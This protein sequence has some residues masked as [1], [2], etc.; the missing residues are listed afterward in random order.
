MTSKNLTEEILTEFAEECYPFDKKLKARV[1]DLDAVVQTIND[2]YHPLVMGKN[3]FI[4]NPDT[5]LYEK[6]DNRIKALINT[7][8]DLV[9]YKKKRPLEVAYNRVTVNLNSIVS[10]NEYPFDNSNAIAFNNGVLVFS[11]DGQSYELKPYS[12]EYRLTRKFAVDFN[13]EA[14]RSLFAKEL[15]EVWVDDLYVESLYHPIVGSILQSLPDHQPVK[16][17]WFFVGRG[18]SGK[19]TYLT[20]LEK[21]IGE[22]YVGHLSMQ[23]LCDESNRFDR[24]TLID[25]MLNVGDDI[26]ESKLR[27]VAIFKNLTGSLNHSVEDKGKSKINARITAANVFTANY[28]PE[29][30][31]DVWEDDAFWRRIQIVRFPNSFP[32]DPTWMRTH[33][34]KEVFESFILNVVD[35]IAK[36][37]HGLPD[38]DIYETRD[39]WRFCRP[40]NSIDYYADQFVQDCIRPAI[41]S[42]VTHKEVQQSFCDYA[43]SYTTDG[44]STI[45]Q[46]FASTDTNVIGKALQAQGGLESF[47]PTIDGKRTWCYRNIELIDNQNTLNRGGDNNK[48]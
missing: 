17:V 20:F 18:N 43:K 25:K 36:Y 10:E 21:C 15:G 27:S 5:G 4:Y 12:H 38:V 35:L 24:F 29:V 11:D 26:A 44:Q 31:K 3:V 1:V 23:Q 9:D 33:F 34:R 47:R 41:G 45:F 39:L 13:P 14:D 7:L 2:I 37:W 40:P 32:S 42:Y 22:R 46:Q 30:S 6:E 8:A 28:T 16:R 48:L 19:S